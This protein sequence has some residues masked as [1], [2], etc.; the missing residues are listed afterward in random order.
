M[1]DP[2][3]IAIAEVNFIVLREAVSVVKSAVCTR[4]AGFGK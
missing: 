3:F 2:D 1:S 4:I